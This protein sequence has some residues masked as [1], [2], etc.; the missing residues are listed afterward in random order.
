[1]T[2]YDFETDLNI[3]ADLNN[4][5][6]LTHYSKAINDQIIF[7]IR[8]NQNRVSVEDIQEQNKKFIKLPLQAF[9]E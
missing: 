6:D 7:S 3:V 9:Q 5:K 1:M 4:Y 2:F 8:D